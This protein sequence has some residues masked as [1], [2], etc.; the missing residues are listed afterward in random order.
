MNMFRI[1]KF[2]IVG[3]IIGATVATTCTGC[4]YS[5]K[6]NEAVG[7]VKKLVEHTPIVCGDYTEVDISLGALRDG[8]GSMSREDIEL[9]V[10]DANDRALLKSAA[11]TGVIVKV[12]YDIER[13]VLCGPKII[14]TSVELLP[15]EDK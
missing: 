4:G 15:T 7:Q 3:I 2:T 14:L 10:N 12:T 1:A 8:N 13:L 9:R 6:E 5:A 11:E